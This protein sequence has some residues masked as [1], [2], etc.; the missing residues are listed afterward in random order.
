M[1]TVSEHRRVPSAI[2]LLIRGRW[3]AQPGTGGA[4]ILAVRIGSPTGT[5]AP[6]ISAPFP[7]TRTG[8]SRAYAGRRVRPAVSSTEVEWLG[9]LF[10]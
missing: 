7:D 2:S 4:V 3:T 6:A 5:A 8:F 9:D 1:R 10:Q